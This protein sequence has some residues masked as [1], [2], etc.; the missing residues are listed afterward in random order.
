M[1]HD[2]PPLGA[3]EI[4]F[5]RLDIFQDQLFDAAVQTGGGQQEAAQGHPS[6]PR[7][8]NALSTM[9]KQVNLNEKT[10]LTIYSPAAS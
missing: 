3:G 8:G 2:T 9:T 5:F 7:N 6:V 4:S 1:S 10:T